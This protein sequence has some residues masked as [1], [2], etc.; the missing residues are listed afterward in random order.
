M[1]LWS[2]LW[3]VSSV[4][5]TALVAIVSDLAV[6]QRR[7][8][9]ELVVVLAINATTLL[10]AGV[11]SIIELRRPGHRIGRLLMLA[12]PLY[13]LLALGWDVGA[14]LEKVVGRD[15]AL[16]LNWLA[17][18]MSWAGIS[19]I[20]G[21][22]PLLFPT[23]SLPGPRWRLPVAILAG[24]GTAGVLAAAVRPGPMAPGIDMVNPAGIGGWP[25]VLRPLVDS[26]FWILIAFIGL[27]VASLISRY[28]H[29]DAIERLQV[30][31]LVAA[32]TLVAASATGNVIENL[33]R[34]DDGYFV[35]ALVFT[36]GVLLM[37]VAIGIAVLRY[38]LYDI[39]RIISRTVGWAIVTGVLV[40]VFAAMI[41]ASQAL[42]SGVTQ[43]QTLAVAASTL[44]TAALFAPVR[45][46]VQRAVDQ[47]FNRA[48]VDAE[49]VTAG[50]AGRLRDRLDLPTVSAE[51]DATVRGALAPRGVAIWV[52]RR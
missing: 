26:V 36:A 29:G 10:Y 33:I 24:L 6:L 12:G 51:V 8:P 3:I 47:R 41:L 25:S 19:L 7:A 4:V 32:V 49:A 52:R 21:W 35:S 5:V 48:R 22:L 43:G 38:K 39:D 27:A 31:W 34:N 28:R 20:A 46:R 23:G 16:I 13:G 9:F 18:S 40:A 30:R 44:V 37:P 15:A 2:L 45:T 14:S 17:I 11:G 42:L 50:F 1:P